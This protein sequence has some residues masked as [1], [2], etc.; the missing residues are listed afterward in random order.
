MI[1]RVELAPGYSVSRVIH[2][3]WQ[4]ARGHRPGA[5][6]A[7]AA[8]NTLARLADAGFT[9]FDCA[10][11]YTWVEEIFGRFLAARPRGAAGIQVHTKLVPDA[12]I[13]PTITRAYV[14][15]IVDRSLKR[16]GAEHLDLVQLHWWDY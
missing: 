4:L 11:I 7:E 10:D 14:E 12:G 9:T 6:D 13:L 3:G 1:P 2:G 5:V 8:V 15:G 16:L